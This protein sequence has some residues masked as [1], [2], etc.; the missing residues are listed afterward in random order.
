MNISIQDFQNLASDNG[1]PEM[2][3]QLGKLSEKHKDLASAITHYTNAISYNDR[4]AKA[5]VS[6]AECLFKLKEYNRAIEDYKIMVQFIAPNDKKSISS[7]HFEIAQIQSVKE[8]Y[9]GA[10][11]ALQIALEINPL[12]VAAIELRGT[13]NVDLGNYENAIADYLEVEK[14]DNDFFNNS[15]NILTNL[16]IINA[17][18]SIESKIALTERAV[19]INPEYDVGYF[20]LGLYY[21]KANELGKATEAFKVAHEKNRLG[22]DNLKQLCQCLSEK[23][24]YENLEIYLE[25]LAALGDNR[26]QVNLANLREYFKHSTPKR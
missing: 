14:I 18:M 19:I 9:K 17:G 2:A 7:L 1:D 13:I 10:L 6:R 12:N 23:Q 8:D 20:N 26:A 11:Y 25:R 16:P 3:Y 15:P 24:D 21:K 5:Y 22:L 4:F